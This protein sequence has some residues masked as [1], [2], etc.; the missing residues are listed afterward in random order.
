MVEYIWP[1]PVDKYNI[2]DEVGSEHQDYVV[3]IKYLL[4]GCDSKRV[5]NEDT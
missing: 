4:F 3:V 5:M 2:V 1:A